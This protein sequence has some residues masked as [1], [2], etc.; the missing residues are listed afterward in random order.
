MSDTTP[1]HDNVSPPAT[2]VPPCSPDH[3]VPSPLDYPAANS[4]FRPSETTSTT[5]PSTPQSPPTSRTDLPHV[6]LPIP[7]TSLN[8]SQSSLAFSHAIVTD[9]NKWATLPQ[10]VATADISIAPDGSFVETSSGHAARELKRR[11]DQYVGVGKDIRSPYA[12]TAFVNQHGKQMYRVGHRDATAPAAEAESKAQQVSTSTDV[13]QSHGRSFKGRSRM[14]V[15]NILPQN[16]LKAGTTLKPTVVQDA[17]APARKLVRRTKSIPDMFGMAV[18]ASSAEDPSRQPT[19]TGRTHSHSVTG[20]DIPR[21]LTTAPPVDLPKPPV[22]DIFSEVMQWPHGSV[23][24][25]PYTS[26]S[27]SVSSESGYIPYPFGLGI[28]FDSPTRRDDPLY[29]PMPRALREMQSFDSSLTARADDMIRRTVPD[30]PSPIPEAQ[31][32]P[33]SSHVDS[34]PTPPRLAVSPFADDSDIP[35][36]DPTLAPLPETSM[37]SRYAP[38]VFDV[39]Q[40]YRGLPLLDRLFPDSAGE[41]TIKMSLRADDSAAPRDDPR[42]VL[43]GEMHA[44]PEVDMDDVSI[45]LSSRNGACS[46]TSSRRGR[47]S[48]DVPSLRISTHDP[49]SNASGRRVLLA[50]TIERWIAQ[51]TSDFNYDELLNFFL[52]YRTYI[53][54]VD[55]CHLL[56]CRFHWSLSGHVTKQDE[57]ARKIVRVRTFVA[58]RY[59]LLTFFMMD[60]LPN[61]ELRLLLASWLNTLV[62]DPVLKKHQDGLSIVRKLIKVVK[63]CKE[64]Y[65]RRRHGSS[66]A[67]QSVSTKPR[68]THVLG[69]KF[70]EAISKDQDDSE[71]D[72]DFAPEERMSVFLGNGGES[73]NTFTFGSAGAMAS[74]TRASGITS[75]SAAIL[76]QPLQRNILQQSRASISVTP[77]MDPLVAQSSQPITFPQ[78]ALSRVFVKTIGRLGRWRRVLNS[79]QTVDTGIAVPANVSAFDL[80]LSG[81]LLGVRGGVEQYLK[82]IEPPSSELLAAPVF[83]T[84]EPSQLPGL[85]NGGSEAKLANAAAQGETPTALTP[86]H[87]QL[88]SVTEVM[89][90]EEEQTETTTMDRPVSYKSSV[91]GVSRGGMSV[92]TH[93]TESFG[94]ILSSRSR[95]NPLV[96]QVQAKP[97]WRFNVVSIDDLDLSDTS[98]EMHGDHVPAPPGLRKPPRKLPLRRDFEFIRRS[99]ESVSSMGIR[100][101]DSVASESSAASIG[102]GLGN[103]IQQWQVNAIVDSLSDDGEDGGVEEALNRLEGQINPKRRKEKAL[104]VDGWVRAIQER[105]AAGAFGDEHPRFFSE[106]DE[107]EE[108]DAYVID[109]HET[110]SVRRSFQAEEGSMPAVSSQIPVSGTSEDSFIATP[111]GSLAGLPA[112]SFEGVVGSG[113][114]SPLRSADAKPAPEDVVPFEILQSRVPSR[115]S[116]S[117]GSPMAPSLG[118]S[119]SSPSKILAP[120]GRKAYRCWVLSVSA[121]MLVQHFSMIDRELFMGIKPEELVMD[122][123]MSCQEV[124]VLDWAQYLKDRARWKAESRFS[125]KTSALAV[126]RGRFNL[127]TNFVISEIILTPPSDKHTLVAKF[128]RIAIKA[129]SY[130]NFNTLVAILA[131]L[132]SEWVNKAMHRHWNRVGPWEMQIFQKLLQFVNPENDFKAM[133]EAISAMVDAK[134]IDVRSHA[135]TITSNSTSDSQSNVPSACVPFVGV[136][137]SQLYRYSKLPDLIDPTAPREPVSMDPQTVSFDSPSHPDVFESLT[138]LPPSMQLEPLINVHKQR[139]IAGAIKDLVAGQHLASRVHFLI[140]KKLFQKCLRIRGLDLGTLHQVYLMY[141]EPLSNR[142]TAFIPL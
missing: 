32:P 137:L 101:R 135:S 47:P 140:D 129:Y 79:R 119:L 68:P 59:W 93:S 53:S 28:T 34:P 5:S 126:V 52:T 55:L 27:V 20:A 131:G 67:R 21:P 110:G 123:W 108:E 109:Q 10:E 98:S 65:T 106:D 7:A 91:S 122:D 92:R 115:P 86:P 43:W 33:E 51:L 76:Q 64:A 112:T 14:S 95:L 89:E 62:K 125:Q 136:Y 39:L 141:S 118:P 6:L 12:I 116:T 60:F 2:L 84:T 88:L 105:M 46:P 99:G 107:E 3:Y 102:G 13:S 139:L 41:T 45:S 66:S 8:K 9:E 69:E 31:F 19:P 56:I 30:A 82:M 48:V 44:I 90:E 71:V 26:S 38:E 127:M 128:I 100:S 25:S 124:N 104:K 81:D 97:P 96:A 83:D 24:P 17:G 61:R 18:S 75:A 133:H 1:D 121:D 73:G 37:H 70:A 85:P 80:E 132:R 58:I 134:P 11:Y 35:P 50:A 54:A 120:A 40:T 77:G 4:V 74:P 130:S 63:D 57:M 142:P 103:G 117:H 29:L 49:S 111:S 36:P 72:L 138:P 15:H 22:G 78:R 114:T 113:P 94:S 23:P 87:Q 16:K 42:F